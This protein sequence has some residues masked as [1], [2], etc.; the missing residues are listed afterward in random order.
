VRYYPVTLNGEIIGY[1]Y[2]TQDDDWASFVRRMESAHDTFRA[3]VEWSRRLDQA[4]NYG[5]SPL[6]ALRH[7]VGKPE[8]PTAG[9]IAAGAQEQRASG[10][11][12]L[13]RLANPPRGEDTPTETEVSEG[14]AY[15][16]EGWDV[17]QGYDFLSAGPVRWLPITRRGEVLGY[18][19]AS[20]TD[21]AAD[22]ID[23]TEAG[24]AGLDA[25]E[26]WVSR[27][28]QAAA[29]GLAPLQ[30]LRRWVGEP[31][32]PVAGG[33]AAGAVEQ[34]APSVEFVQRL[35]SGES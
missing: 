6:Q 32:D 9:G 22:Y 3:A 23:R 8:H 30:A 27:L 28:D 33:I 12:A 21:Y 29:E 10:N 11:A 19:W 15:S 1:L 34:E 26:P 24:T 35:A 4:G 14:L 31:E 20:E 18:L 25:G 16:G 2:A 7:W 17:Q 5:F 13:A